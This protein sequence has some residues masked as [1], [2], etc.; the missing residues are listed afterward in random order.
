MM[1]MVGDDDDNDD[2]NGDITKSAIAMIM[3][4]IKACSMDGSNGDYDII[5]PVIQR[6]LY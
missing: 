6:L 2:D 1:I 4:A 5:F 3:V